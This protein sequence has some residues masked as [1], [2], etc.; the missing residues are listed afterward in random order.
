MAGEFYHKNFLMTRE[1]FL[2][3]IA[4]VVRRIV[5]NLCI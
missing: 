1:E 4:T 5:V 2:P 3:F